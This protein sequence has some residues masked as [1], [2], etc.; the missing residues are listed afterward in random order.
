MHIRSSRFRVLVGQ[1]GYVFKQR[2]YMARRRALD[3]RGMDVAGLLYLPPGDSG[4][5]GDHGCMDVSPSA[6]AIFAS[7]SIKG[8][9][10]RRPGKY[11]LEVK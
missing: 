8:G 7:T 2:E 6:V 5:H 3:Q 1:A 4:S 11:S 9:P 10:P